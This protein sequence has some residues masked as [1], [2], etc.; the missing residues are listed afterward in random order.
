M[1][2]LWYP[3]TFLALPLEIRHTIYSHLL[4]DGSTGLPHL[5]GDNISRTDD[6]RRTVRSVF[7][8]NR[9]IYHEAFDYYHSKNT[10]LLSLISPYYSLKE[11]A[12]KSDALIQRLHCVQSLHLVIETSKEQRIGRGG[13]GNYSFQFHSDSQYPKQQEQ[14]DCFLKLLLKAKEGQRRRKLKDLTLEDWAT[15]RA[16][17][18]VLD[19]DLPVYA[20][21]LAPLRGSTSLIKVVRGPFS[22]PSR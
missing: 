14:W 7:L 15:D 1:P 8:T 5:V 11:V 13:N 22:K 19:A 16:A 20:S 12:T 10:F 3:P 9:Q 17:N 21:L 4:I 6:P 18:E 2:Y